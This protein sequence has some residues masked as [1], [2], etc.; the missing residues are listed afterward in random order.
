MVVSAPTYL[1]CMLF[2]FQETIVEKA[3]AEG[4]SFFVNEIR[5]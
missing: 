2:S 4:G 5:A 1:L 3:S